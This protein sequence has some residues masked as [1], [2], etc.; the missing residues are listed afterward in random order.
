MVSYFEWK[1]NDGFY[2]SDEE[3]LEYRKK[4]KEEVDKMF[5]IGYSFEEYAMEKEIDGKVIFRNIGAIHPKFARSMFGVDPKDVIKV[6]CTIIDKDFYLK[7]EVGK[8]DGYDVSTYGYIDL[9]LSEPKVSLIFEHGTGYMMC[10][11]CDPDILVDR[12]AGMHVKLKV[13]KI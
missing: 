11:H 7:D 12:F 2:A 5:P 1:N 6:R 10:F 8:P 3:A 4:W 9:Q 13:E